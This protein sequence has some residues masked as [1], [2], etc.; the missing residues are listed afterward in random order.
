MIAFSSIA[1]E[2]IQSVIYRNKDPN[3]GDMFTYLDYFADDY[4]NWDLVFYQGKNSKSK[5]CSFTY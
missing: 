3:N 4:N 1:D 2:F 5:K